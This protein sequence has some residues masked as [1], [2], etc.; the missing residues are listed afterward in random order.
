MSRRHDTDGQ[1]KATLQVVYRDEEHGY[2]H[3]ERWI[4]L[5]IGTQVRW[6]GYESSGGGRQEFAEVEA[7]LRALVACWSAEQAR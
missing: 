6:Y 2:G 4:G 7:I 3:W 5:M 1:P